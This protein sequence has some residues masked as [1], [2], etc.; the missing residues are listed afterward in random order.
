MITV[1]DPVRSG[2]VADHCVVPWAV[3]DRPVLVDQVTAATPTLSDAV[4]E[5]WSEDAEVDTMLPPG[6]VMVRVGGVVSLPAGGGGGGGGGGGAGLG[7]GGAGVLE[8]CAA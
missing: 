7:G 2:I 3:P 8:S 1:L 4:P 6:D 5:N